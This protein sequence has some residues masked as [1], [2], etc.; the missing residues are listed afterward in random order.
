MAD[1]KSLSHLHPGRGLGWITL[2]ASLHGILTRLKAQPQLYPQLDLSYSS[3]ESVL[4]PVVLTLPS[5]GVRL[6]FDGPD[7]RLRLIEIIDFSKTT[8]L[9]KNTELVRRPTSSAEDQDRDPGPVQG[10]SF[11]H[12]YNRLFGP[13]YAGEYIP[14]ESGHS[15]G[16]Y[17][18]SYPG[19]AIRF[20]LKHKSWSEKADFVS[21]LSNA[22]LPATSVAI[23]V[24]SSWPEARDNLFT[25]APSLPR[26][27]TLASKIGSETAPD[28]VEEVIIHGAGKLELLRRSSPSFTIVLG[29]TTPQDLVA[30]LGPPDAI[31]R[32]ALTRLSI[33]ASSDP[34]PDRFSPSLEPSSVGTDRSS[35]HSL[36][37]DDSESEVNSVT[38]D[39]TDD[40]QAENFYNYFHHGFDILV[41]HPT[42]GSPPFPSRRSHEQVGTSSTSELVVTKIFLHANVPGSYSFNRHRRSRWIIPVSKTTVLDSEMRFSE[43]SASLKELWQDSYASAEEESKMQRGMVLNRGWGDEDSPES[44]IELLGGFDRDSSMTGET[45]PGTTGIMGVH[46]ASLSNTQLFGF[47]GM[48][49]EVLKNDLVTCVTIY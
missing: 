49:F 19:L 10:P 25:V 6:R 15:T 16:T 13:A 37:G 7:Q 22:A 2:G 43:I 20:P 46:G 1:T 48:L 33:H 28:E 47:P 24:G 41:S 18:L 27:L 30:E 5:N 11:R 4:D 38:G 35:S 17:V 45:G 42:T 29:Q 31:F 8:F 34:R 23:F 44:S 32:K 40:A 9:Y 39:G 14:P 21:L 26:S 12:I 36:I 3:A